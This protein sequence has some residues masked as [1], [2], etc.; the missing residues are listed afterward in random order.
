[1]AGKIVVGG[2]LETLLRKRACNSG[3]V[4]GG[5]DYEDIKE[6]LGYEVVAIT[7]GEELGLPWLSE[8]SVISNGAKFLNCYSITTVAK[9]P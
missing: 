8:G 6:L 9:H 7:G 5:F 2:A 4:T 1:M 3:V